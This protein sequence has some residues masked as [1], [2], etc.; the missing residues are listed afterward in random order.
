MLHWLS[1]ERSDGH[2]FLS[3]RRTSTSTW[4]T[5][6]ARIV[7][8]P[9]GITPFD[10]ACPRANE[11]DPSHRITE[12]ITDRDLTLPRARDSRPSFFSVLPRDNTVIHAMPHTRYMLTN[13]LP[14]AASL[15]HQLPLEPVDADCRLS[16][17]HLQHQRQL[18]L[19]KPPRNAHP[20]RSPDIPLQ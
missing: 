14:C 20:Q 11:F 12:A 19:T 17:R 5:G 15:P 10:F 3:G 2:R 8:I 6:G 18:F 4:E 7:K 1:S 16:H 13:R 9:R